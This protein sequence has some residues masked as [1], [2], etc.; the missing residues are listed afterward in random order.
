VCFQLAIVCKR[1]GVASR[2]AGRAIGEDFHFRLVEHLAASELVGN[3]Y[4]LG[5]VLAYQGARSIA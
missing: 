2:N 4:D 1:R 3:R 5:P